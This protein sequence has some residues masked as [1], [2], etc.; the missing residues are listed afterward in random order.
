MAEKRCYLC[1]GEADTKDHVPP[2]G[3]FPEPRPSNLITVDCCYRCNQKFTKIDEEFRLFVS[4]PINRSPEG[5]TIWEQK[6]LRSTLPSRRIAKAIR[7][8]THRQI[9]LATESGPIPAVRIEVRQRPI[10]LCLI[11]IT[12]GLLA[13]FHPDLDYSDLE[14]RVTPF[15][16]FKLAKTV[17]TMPELLIYDERGGSVFRFWRGIATDQTNAGLWFFC[18]FNA[19]SFMVEHRIRGGF[20]SRDVKKSAKKRRGLTS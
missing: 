12:K 16:Q 10:K 17:A 2:K 19:A 1:K 6:V 5:R 8:I 20:A 13:T 11:R 18:F 3:L 9:F 4:A 15:D 7:K 14:F